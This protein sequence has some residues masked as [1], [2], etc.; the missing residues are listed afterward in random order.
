VAL[1]VNEW[2]GTIEP[3][4]ILKAVCPPTCGECQVIGERPMWEELEAELDAD[5]RAWSPIARIRAHHDIDA[6][7]SAPALFGPAGLFAAADRTGAA[8]PRAAARGPESAAA[9]GP[10]SGAARGPA[11]AAARAVIDA[12]PLIDRRAQGISAVCGELL[13]GGESVLGVCA[14]ARRRADGLATLV[15]GLALEK[16]AFAAISWRDLVADPSQANS[17]RHIVLIDPPPVAELLEVAARAP[18]SGGVY[19]GWGPAETAFA[20]TV[21]ESELDLRPHLTALYRILRE[22]D[23]QGAS[24]E[25]LEAILRGDGRYPR[26]GRLCGRLIRVLTQLQLATYDRTNRTLQIDPDAPKTSL[27]RSTVYTAYADRLAQARTYLGY[28]ATQKI[29]AAA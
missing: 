27:D 11:S 29:A 3:R 17:F 6:E 10:G 4:L 22:S 28:E 1:E 26:P 25:S 2:N 12:R 20:Q 9:R 23:A 19:L 15:A 24:G 16:T 18:V 13:A 5:P 8:D 14:D 21:V 7:L